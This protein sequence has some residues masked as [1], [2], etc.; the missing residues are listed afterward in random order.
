MRVVGLCAQMPRTIEDLAADIGCGR[1][2]IYRHVQ[3]AIDLELV[4]RHDLIKGMPALLAASRDGHRFAHSGLRP[5]RIS[6]GGFHHLVVCSQIAADLRSRYPDVELLSE[7]ELRLRESI[8]QRPIASAHVGHLP[9]SR[10]RLHRPDLVLIPAGRQP[11]AIEVEL[12]PKAPE[13]LRAVMTGW[14]RAHWVERVV[15]LCPEGTTL[16]AVQAAARA[17]RLGAERLS[18]R[19]LFEVGSSP[20]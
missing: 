1:S 18:V 16:R 5:A 8:E 2:E 7:F 11:T 19:R 13:R 15:Y 10:P 20:S 4:E 17:A 6:H 14:R 3:G 9:N 12:T